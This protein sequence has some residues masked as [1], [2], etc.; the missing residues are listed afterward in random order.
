MH[1]ARGRYRMVVLCN[2]VLCP[3]AH[4]SR[5]KCFLFL[6]HYIG[7]RGKSSKQNAE[8]TKCMFWFSMVT[9][10]KRVKMLFPYRF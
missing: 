5:S 6:S 10:L 8:V 1:A 7:V 3:P 2:T 9:D 4:S